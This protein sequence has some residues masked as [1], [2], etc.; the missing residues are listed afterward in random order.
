MKIIQQLKSNQY[1]VKIKSKNKQKHHK[2]NLI[3]EVGNTAANTMYNQSPKYGI[4]IRAN[5][6]TAI[7]GFHIKKTNEET[8]FDISDYW[9]QCNNLL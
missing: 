8:N 7:V 6:H 1:L 5:D 4:R 3:L 9:T 2:N